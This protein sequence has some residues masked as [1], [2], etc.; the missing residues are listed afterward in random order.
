MDLSIVIISFNTVDLTDQCLG[1]VIKSLKGSGIRYEIIVVDNASDD[2]SR[3]MIRAKYPKV[4]IIANRKNIGF[5]KANNIGVLKSLGEYILLLNSDTLIINESITKLLAFGKQHPNAIVGGKLLNFNRSPQ[6]SCG[7]F[8]SLPVVFAALF[9]KGDVIGLTRYSPDS[10]RKV[11]WMSGACLLAPKKIFIQFPFDE[12]IFM[13]MEEIDMFMR[14]KAHGIPAY[15][16]PRAL[17]V[18][19]GAGSSTNKRKGPILNIYRGLLYLYK[20]HYTERQMRVLKLLL[21]IKAALVWTICAIFGLD[22]TKEM[23]AEAYSL[24]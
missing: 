22:T 2:G 23:Y 15:F 20:K 14:A 7:P 6:T 12:H 10:V 4:K 9:L 8:F 11:D 18:H 24:V 13:Y 3:A 19:L 21:K 1:S 5:G 16:Y 17:I